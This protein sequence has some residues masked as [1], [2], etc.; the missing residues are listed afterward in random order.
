MQRS[1]SAHTPSDC[2]HSGRFIPSD[3]G[4]GQLFRDYGEKYISVYRPS[5]LEIKLIRSIRVCKTPALGGRIY[6]CNSCGEKKYV[7]YSCGNSRCPKCQGIKRIQ[8]QDKIAGTLF[9][10][11]YVHMVF[12]MPHLLNGLARGNSYAVYNCLM[13]SAWSSLKECCEDEKNLGAIPGAVMVLHTFGSDLKYHVHVHALVSFGGI[14]HT[15]QWRWP[16]RKRKIVP[17]RQI[18]GVFRKHFLERLQ[19]IYGQLDSRYNYKDLCDELMKKSWCV[20]AEP[21]TVNTKVIGEYLGKYI[22]RIGLSKN[23]FHY[24]RVNNEVTILFKDYRNKDQQNGHAPKAELKM[25]PLAAILQIVQHCSPAYFQK[26]RYY[27]L[28]S[29]ACKIKYQNKIPECI[30]NNPKSIRT[31]FQILHQMLGLQG[32]ACSHCGAPDFQVTVIAAD[33]KWITSWLNTIPGNKGSPF[34]NSYKP[35]YISVHH[36]NEMLF[37]SL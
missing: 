17:F 1:V 4:I 35:S 27:G 5:L 6:E 2:R 12:T 32:L 7:Y 36:G 23:R 20:H 37:S 34:A 31:L 9:K 18:R 19:S 25:Q 15:D 29:S 8:W 14:D 10:T 33:K 26:C 21:A 3:N 28:H 24:D 16:K 11:P 30:K 13:R 22:C